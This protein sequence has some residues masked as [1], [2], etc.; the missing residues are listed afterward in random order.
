VVRRF[1]PALTALVAGLAALGIT[2]LCHEIFGIQ[3]VTGLSLHLRTGSGPL[4]P[5]APVA[6]IAAV[7]LTLS[8]YLV[9]PVRRMV[10]VL[11][12][13]VAIAAMYLGIALGPDVLGAVFL[14]VAVAGAVLTVVG[15]PGGR[16][17]IDEVRAGLVSL[18]V[19]P[20]DVTSALDP[21]KRA[22]A[23]DVTDGDGARLRV[24]AFGRDQRD[25]Q[26]AAKAWRW[27]MYREPGVP[28][29]GSRLQQV[30]HIGYG[31][32]LAR[33][34]GVTVPDVV[35]TAPFGAG[36][37]VLLTRAS[38]G[39]RL[40]DVPVERVDDALLA[41]VWTAAGAMHDAGIGHGRLDAHHLRIDGEEVVVDGFS[42][43]DMSANAFWLDRDRV[44]VLV[45][46]MGIVGA[47]RAIAAARQAL[48]DDTLGALIPMVQPVS[49]PFG[50]L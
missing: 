16:P 29:F 2:A 50:V 8:P 1:V 11:V 36:D 25:A 13:F 9:R 39:T 6:S 42:S 20:V 49:L 24:Y 23:F 46:T 31:M 26:L 41:R 48:G 22:S 47:D 43:V 17:S 37:A 5:T 34:A 45:S 27:T 10:V 19:E 7:G 4:F 30:E 32:M 28:L 40:A 21:P 18:G 12:V 44:T 35:R 3:S 14:G 38:S 15:A 33:R